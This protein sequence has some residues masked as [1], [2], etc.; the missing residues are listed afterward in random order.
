MDRLMEEGFFFAFSGGDGTLNVKDRYF[1]IVQAVVASLSDFTRLTYSLNDDQVYN[2][3]LVEGVPRIADASVRTIASIVN[4]IFIQASSQVAFFLEYIDPDN[5]E[6]APAI[7]QVTP[8]NST[9]YQLFANSDGTGTQYTSTG[10]A[11][12]TFFAQTALN[13]IN[14]GTG[15][16]AW[17]TRYGI[18][19]KPIHRKSRITSEA[20][21]S[22]SQALYGQKTFRISN[23]LLG[24][25]SHN[26]DYSLF[27]LDKYKNPTAD[28]SAAILNK[29]PEVLV[30]GLADKVTLTD[31]LTGI[32]GEY[33]VQS[34]S[35]DIDLV[36]GLRHQLDFDVYKYLDPEVLILD[37]P[38]YGLLDSR[39]LGF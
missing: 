13:V 25:Q 35:H 31:S 6:P 14:N 10:S 23:D 20:E 7:S 17:L 16:D 11:S 39:K 30:I 38:A 33:I 28:I 15:T 21:D 4:P 9:D 37:D 19:G 3:I 26:T 8:V 18:R 2:D 32:A 27:L 34:I 24:D 5:S 36:D 29:F 22:S 1:D 12:V